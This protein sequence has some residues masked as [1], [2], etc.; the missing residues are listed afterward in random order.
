MLNELY[1]DPFQTI[2]TWIIVGITIF[3]NTKNG[4]KRFYAVPISTSL[5][6]K[7]WNLHFKMGF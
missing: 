3:H 2:L 6:P 5:T 1:V 4:V 7:A